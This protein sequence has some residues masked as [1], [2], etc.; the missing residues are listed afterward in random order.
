[1]VR[2]HSWGLP[3]ALALVFLSGTVPGWTDSARADLLGLPPK[4][5]PD[6]LS[7]WI[8]VKYEFDETGG[9]GGV[10]TAEGTAWSV[11]LDDGN[12][13]H[14]IQNGAF[15]IHLELDTAGNPTG[16]NGISITGT[17][18]T[19]GYDSGT[20]LTGSILRF[21][22]E[23]APTGT[24]SGP[25]LFEFVFDA[26]EDEDLSPLYSAAAGHT[27]YVALS[28]YGTSFQG[29]FDQNFGNHQNLF[30]MLS[31]VSDT[32][33]TPEP[34]VVIMWAFLGPV[35]AVFLVRTWRRRRAQS[36]HRE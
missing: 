22:F 30:G 6:V 28:A 12:P 16:G 8:T 29:R 35:A 27:A 26:G 3:T 19:A 17:V 1:M 18:P 31:S 4:V 21:G 20:L 5:P 13:P 11:E 25:T 32:F 2:S 34:S 7:Q 14:P 33:A 36:L 24:G 15:Q 9:T 23:D 10:F